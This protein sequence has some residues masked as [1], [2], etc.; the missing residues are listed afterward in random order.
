MTIPIEPTE[1]CAFALDRA[2]PLAP[3]R[4]RFYLPPGTIYLDG[5]SLGPLSRD[6]EAALLQT[7]EDWKGRAIA[8]W[9]EGPRPWLGRAREIGALA[10]GMMGAAPDEVVHSATTTVN[11]HALAASFYRPEGRRVKILADALNFP[12]DLYALRGQ[13]RLRGRSPERDLVLVP[14][15]DGRTLDEERIA[16]MLTEEV[17]L[18]WLPSVLY[19]SGQLLDMAYLTARAHEKGVLVGFDCSHSAGA[20]PHALDSWGVDCAAWCSYKYLNGGPGASAFLYVNRRHFDREPLLA[21]WFGNRPETMFDMAL[22]FEPAPDAGRW[23]ISSPGVLGSS[24]LRGSLAMI[25][26]AG[27]EAIRRKSLAMTAYLVALLDEYLAAPPYAF[28]V[29]S[30]RED[31]RRGGH[32]AVERDE[33]AE[34]VCEALIARGVVPD[35]RPPSVIRLCPSPLYGTFHEI[36]QTA[37]HLKAIVDGGEQRPGS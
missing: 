4:D 7:L 18:A 1:A 22:D 3:F 10:A 11:I 16:A 13:L 34:R 8:G 30:P 27:I 25:E 31:A 23:Q 17:A 15:D 28:R 19:R 9:F 5:N 20:L 29:G 32:V 26:D 36:W 33:G 12:T 6:A 24:T 21:G 14:S 2:D 37:G 35:F